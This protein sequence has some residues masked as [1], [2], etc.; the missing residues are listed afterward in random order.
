MTEK[1]WKLKDIV[2]SPE[3]CREIPPGKFKHSALVW[4]KYH[5]GSTSDVPYVREREFGDEA[6]DVWPAPT[7]EEILCALAHM[8]EDWRIYP[9][10]ALQWLMYGRIACTG[11]TK[12]GDALPVLQDGNIAGAL[13][14]LWLKAR[15]MEEIRAEMEIE[16]NKE[17][18]EDEQGE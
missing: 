2:P 6:S 12:A 3:L 8:L 10:T 11:M 18:A 15:K 7:A 5:R 9:I 17:E 4:T 1:Y 14:K 13:L 16:A